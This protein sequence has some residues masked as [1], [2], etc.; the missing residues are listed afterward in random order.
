MMVYYFKEYDTEEGL[1]TKQGRESTV[2]GDWLPG[3]E[4]SP[5]TH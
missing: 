3:M 1:L 5:A 4:P 2:F